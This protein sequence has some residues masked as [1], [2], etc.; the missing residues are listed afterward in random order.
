M[1]AERI[2]RRREVVTRTGLSVS[3]IR[4]REISDPDFPKRVRLGPNAVGW[5]ES[6]VSGWIRSLQRLRAGSES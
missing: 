5:R 6:E 2:L 3:T 1:P 4:R